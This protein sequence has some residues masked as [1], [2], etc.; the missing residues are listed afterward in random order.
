MSTE[1]RVYDDANGDPVVIMM[2]R[3][4]DDVSRLV[5]LLNSGRCEDAETA[6]Y[7]TRALRRHNGGRDAMKLLAR[8]GGPDL[9]VDPRAGSTGPVPAIDLDAIHARIAAAG[10]GPWLTDPEYGWPM[11]DGNIH[12][13]VRNDSGDGHDVVA[14]T[15][16]KDLHPRSAADAE[17]IAHARDDIPAL[18][19]ALDATRAELAATAADLARLRCGAR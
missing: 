10:R 16:V 14:L 9:L 11:G 18:L 8:H 3:G 17:F 4:T 12:E 5:N 15:G 6:E 1:A 2:T 19:A 13:A 7:V